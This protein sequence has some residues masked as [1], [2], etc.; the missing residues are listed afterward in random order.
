MAYEHLCMNCMKEKGND[1]Q[2]PHCHFHN[3]SL[4]LPPF[5]PMRSMVGNRYLVGAVLDSN[6][7]GTTY[8]GFDTQTETA[9]HIREFLP[10]SIAKRKS[11]GTE[12]LV[13]AGTEDSYTTMLGNFVDLWSK[14]LKM[15]GLSA[16]IKVTDLLQEN[17]TAYAIT[18]HVEGAQSLRDYL[19]S[20]KNGYLSW[21][22]TRVLFMPVLSTL[23]TL[24]SSGIIHRG[25]S[26]ATLYLY[27]DHKIRISGFSIPECRT[28]NSGL[29]T[30]IFPG[31]TPVEQLGVQSAA[32][33]WTDIYSFAAVLYRVLIGRT[34]IDAMVRMEND[35]MMIPAEFAEKLPAHVINALINA[36]QVLPED[37]TRNIDRF[38]AELSASQVAELQ[39]EYEQEEKARRRAMYAQANAAAAA[40]T[41]AATSEPTISAT[42]VVGQADEP[43]RTIVGFD[44]VSQT[45]SGQNYYQEPNKSENR[46]AG[47]IAFLIVIVIALVIM[48]G[49]LL[50]GKLGDIGLNTS[51]EDTTTITEE[52]EE[53]VEVPSFVGKS[54]A[55]IQSQK[56]FT[57]NF[58]FETKEEYSSS[59]EEGY[60]I[61]QDIDE[62]TEVSVGTTITLTISKGVEK[63]RMPDVVGMTLTEATAT[64][65][66]AGFNVSSIEKSNPGDEVSGTVAS[67]NYTVGESYEKGSTV[68]L[69]VWGEATTTTTEADDLDDL[70]SGI[71]DPADEEDEE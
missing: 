35:E 20:T 59:V 2:C 18:E 56:T 29:T 28:V 21:K 61:R 16:L 30:E 67:T 19:L 31:Y 14:L 60:V 62:G 47:L 58:T 34:P 3:D 51:D 6:G 36:L 48:L 33:P 55:S 40:G 50:S 69:T 7:D 44:S 53:T 8:M 23:A 4:Q 10:D 39:S 66:N 17:N 37:R 38:R 27:P 42:Q 46:R 22:D 49:L 5:L 65:Q 26:P 68:I 54:W 11:G 41:A 45:N 52:A 13:R 63:V 71:F 25:I 15:N 57:D 32:G 70:I 12:L 64:L 43:T 9:V 1:E 24:H